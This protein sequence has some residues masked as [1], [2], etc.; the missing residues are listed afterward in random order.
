MH[1]NYARDV[2]LNLLRVF[3]VVAEL[4]SVTQAAARLYLTQPAIRRGIAE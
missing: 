2:D 3:V 4:R 1:E